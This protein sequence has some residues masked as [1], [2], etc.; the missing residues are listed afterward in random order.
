MKRLLLICSLYLL[1]G[2]LSYAQTY[3]E[4]PAQKAQFNLELTNLTTR[5]IYGWK[6]GLSAAVNINNRMSFSYVNLVELGTAQESEAA[7][8]SKD[9]FRGAQYQYYINP[10]GKLNVGLGLMVGFYNEQFL[11]VTPSVE[12][13]YVYNERWIAGVGVSRVDSY[14]KFDF[15]VGLR[16]FR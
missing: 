3:Y 6:T 12:L 2:S 16:L 9:T 4:A 13:K 7:V 10:N 1:L 14:P 8:S 5:S 11:A 15:R